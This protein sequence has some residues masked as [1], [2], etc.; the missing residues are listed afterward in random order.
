MEARRRVSRQGL[1]KVSNYSCHVLLEIQRDEAKTWFMAIFFIY[2]SK[3][4]PFITDVPQLILSDHIVSPLLSQKLDA[5]QATAL[6]GFE[7]DQW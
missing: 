1:L 6:H 7:L 3:G 2:R 4:D 5:N